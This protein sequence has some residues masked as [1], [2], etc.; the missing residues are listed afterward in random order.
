MKER[1]TPARDIG[2]YNAYGNEGWND[3]LLVGD[4]LSEPEE[5]MEK[6]L[7][8][9]EVEAKE[10]DIEGEGEMVKKVL[11]ERPRPRF[12]KADEVGDLKSLNRALQKTLYLVV[13]SGKGQWGFPSAQLAK[14]ESLHTVS[15]HRR[16]IARAWNANT[17]AE[18]REDHRS[19]WRFEHEYLGRRKYTNWPP[20]IQL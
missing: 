9:A 17:S 11:V 15:R 8:D 3:E 14:H 19:D 7:R 1:Q 4:R 18:C 20:D 2:V 12:T 6:L 10:G 13:K 16:A 5:Q